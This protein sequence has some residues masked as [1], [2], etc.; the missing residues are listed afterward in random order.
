[1]PVRESVKI[2][3]LAVLLALVYNAFSPKGIPLIRVAPIKVATSDSVLF[4]PESDSSRERVR[5]IAPLHDSALARLKAEREI[6]RE[7]GYKII[8]LGQLQK[9]LDKRSGLL[10]DARNEDEFAKGH[11]K[12]ARNIPGLDAQKHFEELIP[13][14]RDTLI[15]IYCTNPECPLGRMLAEFVG[16]MEFHKIF[17]YDDGW[18]G[19][20]KAGLPAD[21]SR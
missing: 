2:V 13:I 20:E 12:G 15:L 5:V 14:P 10:I 17:L 1:M 9:L 3:A 6:S 7:Q 19:W 18:D 8:S 16:A 11:I 4:G 21:T